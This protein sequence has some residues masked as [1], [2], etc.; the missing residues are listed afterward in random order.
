M[1]KYQEIQ[2]ECGEVLEVVRGN[3]PISEKKTDVEK[4]YMKL[5][6]TR[7]GLSYQSSISRMKS[8]I[9]RLI[10]SNLNNDSIF[11]TLTYAE[12]M[13]EESQAR[14]DWKN[15][16]ARLNYHYPETKKYLFVIEKQKR[17]AYHFHCVLFDA[18]FIPYDALVKIWGKGHIQ[19]GS[20]ENTANLGAY[21]SAEMGKEY[22]KQGIKGK[23]YGRSFGLKEYKKNVFISDQYHQEELLCTD[24]RI[25]KEQVG[26]IELQTYSKKQCIQGMGVEFDKIPY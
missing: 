19:I 23:R 6:R 17:G 20:I 4:E 25:Y 13:I 11:F 24:K 9:R 7:G 5:K 15:F 21:M 22:Q 18:G 3:F 12:N 8:R 14:K 1:N 2:Y 26:R 16:I 10:N